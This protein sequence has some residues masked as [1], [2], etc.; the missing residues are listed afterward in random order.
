[1]KMPVYFS[2]AELADWEQKLIDAFPLLYLE[3]DVEIPLPADG[4][5]PCNLRFG[6]EF[7]PGLQGLVERFSQKASD[8]VQRLLDIVPR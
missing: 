6:F 8:L 1:M 2:R 4:S 3:T 5:A 7:G